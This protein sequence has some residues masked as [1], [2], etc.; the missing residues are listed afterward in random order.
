MSSNACHVDSTADEQVPVVR[1]LVNGSRFF[2]RQYS[3]RIK[4]SF[5]EPATEF[6]DGVMVLM[7]RSPPVERIT[8]SIFIAWVSTK[9]H[10]LV[11]C[12]VDDRDAAEDGSS[13][14]KRLE[15]RRWGS[16][17]DGSQAAVDDFLPPLITAVQPN[18]IASAW[19][20]Q[21]GD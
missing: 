5:V 12:S 20:N 8:D 21:F 17:R 15:D 16:S 6:F 19:S 14:A 10:D 1:L 18:R 11:E 3:Q 9:V 13:V 7:L 2:G 4:A